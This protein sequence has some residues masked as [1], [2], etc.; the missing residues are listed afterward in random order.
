MKYFS[1]W[2]KTIILINILLMNISRADIKLSEIESTL[3][4]EIKTSLN[5]VKINPEGPL[6]LLRGLIY[7]K[8]ECMYNKRFFAPEIDTKYNLEED[9]SDCKRQ[10]YYTYT[11]DEQKDKAYKALSENEMD[12]YTENYHTHLI[13][14]FP[15]PTGDVTIETRGN[16][17]FIQ[18]LRAEKVEKYALHIL[19]MLLLFSEG[20]NIPIEV[21]NSVLK[22]YEKDKKDEIY[23]KVPMAIPWIST[24]TNELET[25]CQ[26]KA[27]RLIIFFKEN[28]NSSE[29]LSMLNDRC[30]KASVISGKFLNSPKFLIQSYIFGFID[31]ANQAKE[32][33]QVVH[34]MTEKYVPKTKILSRSGYLYDRLFKP[35]GAEEGTDC[36]ALM[37]DIEQIKSMY[38]V[39]PF[40]DSTEI[41][42]YR[43]IPLYNRKTKLFSDNRLED[44]SNCVECVILSLF[45]CLA[46]DPA[47]RIYRTDHMGD[48]SEELKEFFSLENQPVD[49]TKAEFQ[50]EWCK[51]V[52]DLKNPRIAYCTGRN[53]LDC[54]LINMLM[55]IAEVVNAPEEEKDKILGFSQYLNDKHGEFD[56]K[57]YDAVEKYTESLLKH[58]SKTK[59]IEIE[60]SEVESTIY[61]NGRYDISGDII[62]RFQHNGIYNTIV[63]EISDQH[64]SIEMKSPTMKFT[65]LRVNKM[66]KMIKSCKNRKT[67]I[68]NLFLIYAGYEMRKI[69][70]NEENKKYI[71]NEI[72]NVVE[73]NFIDI[74]RLLLI[75]KISDLDYK[76][77]LLTGSIVY[78]MDKKLFPCHPIVRF[79]SNILG[80]TELDNQ[81]TQNRILPSIVAANLHSTREGNLNYPKIQLQEKTYNYILTNLSLQEFVKYTL[82]YD[83][84][85]FIMWIKYCIDK[86]DPDK[87]PFLNLL[88]SSLVNEIVCDHLFKDDSMK[89]SKIIDELIIKNYPSRKDK[90]ISEIHFIWIVY[91][92]ARENPNIELIKENI[93][94]IHSA[95][96]ITLESRSYTEECFG[97]DKVVETLK[98]LKDS[99]CD[100][101][102]SIRKINKIIFI[103][104]LE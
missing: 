37:K 46:Y 42:A 36:M 82:D 23:F 21:T 1:I 14:L 57:L 95:K 60:L 90:L 78:S 53:E 38:K 43:S 44:Y 84:S 63:L 103:L 20:V 54:G 8:M 75:K 17:S 64:S 7:Q 2:T 48:V 24:V 71:K 33:I 61:N 55:V 92:C 49:T 27:K 34:S 56:D 41:P 96:Y 86:I 12:L 5:S 98:K 62:I 15:S 68:E 88:L 87:N 100:N 3:K 51:V 73:N 13:D 25:I 6:N 50:K 65:D 69:R 83:I 58:L 32:F 18:F 72:Q 85:I 67:F 29:V 89:Y 19:A 59:N 22:V 74:N 99:L 45:C 79:T 94:A 16:Q 70:D 26:K 4:F 93:N 10:N 47:E 104:E 91:I 9:E 66:N 28:S 52:A 97:F 31:T 30:T 35:T 40:L 81:N 77:E 76:I 80:S 102:D 11:R 39:F 101:E